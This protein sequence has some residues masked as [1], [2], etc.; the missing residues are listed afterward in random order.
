MR[1]AFLLLLRWNCDLYTLVS[2]LFCSHVERY[3]IGIYVLFILTKQKLKNN[4]CRGTTYKLYLLS[5]VKQIFQNGHQTHDGVR[6]ILLNHK[7]CC[8]VLFQN[9][10]H[11]KLLDVSQVTR[12]TEL[13]LMYQL[14]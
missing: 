3:L 13:S 6:N 1:Y 5:F 14:F 11:D 8:K 4:R 2:M 12:K 7:F 10:L 9:D